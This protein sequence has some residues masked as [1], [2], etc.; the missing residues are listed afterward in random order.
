MSKL[1]II[2]NCNQCY[3]KHS[4]GYCLNEGLSLDDLC[5][6]PDWC[7]L[8]NSS[9]LIADLQEFDGTDY[10]HPAWWR[11][12]EQTVEVFCQHVNKIL[13]GNDKD[14]GVSAE[15]WHSTRVRLRK[16]IKNE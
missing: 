14:G 4:D 8:Y 7:P 15:P 11:G 5:D 10:A 3:Y 9:S 16:L 13:D 1:L 2:N 6:I 12:H